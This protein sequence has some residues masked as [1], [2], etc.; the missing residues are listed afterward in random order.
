[1]TLSAKHGHS[2]EEA[3]SL[4]ADRLDLGQTKEG[5]MSIRQTLRQEA[6]QEGMQEGIQQT[7]KQMLRDGAAIEKVVDR[8][9]VV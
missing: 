5:I 8:K 1:M 2:E 4:F 9:S 3:A 6:L 7:A